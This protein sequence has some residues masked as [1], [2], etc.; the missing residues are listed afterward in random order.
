MDLDEILIEEVRNR[1][2]LYDLGH[3][4][5]K[6]LKKKNYAWK[7][8]AAHTKMGELECKRKWKSLRDSYKRG[9]KIEQNA[10]GRGAEIP[11]K[12]W[13]Y[14]E[15][16]SFLDNVK[17]SRRLNE[18]EEY[19]KESEVLEI[20]NMDSA[21]LSMSTS[22]SSQSI[23][24]SDARRQMKKDND[25]FQKFLDLAGASISETCGAFVCQAQKQHTTALHFS[26][27][28]AK[29]VE[30]GLPPYVVNQIEAKVS[31]LVFGEINKF[32]SAND[33]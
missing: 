3:R 24:V 17:N 31:A 23:S 1:P 10:S 19:I 26:T 4:D 2:L 9:K 8:V 25:K 6:N 16:I 20:E 29:I 22:E 12:T 28:A 21:N 27:L 15:A 30:A 14:M 33:K 11:R 13:K 18:E 5:Y 32:Y 7:E